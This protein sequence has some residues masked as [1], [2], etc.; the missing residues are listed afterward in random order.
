MQISK[1]P[2]VTVIVPGF[3]HELYVK[4]TITSIVNQ[5]YGFENIQL[6]TTNDASTDSTGLILEELSKK[7]NF[8][9][10]NN[11][12]NLGVVK[13]LNYML[14]NANGKYISI[15]A[16]DDYWDKDKLFKQVTLMESLDMEYAMCHT[17]APVIDENNNLIFYQDKGVEFQGNIFPKILVENS[18][19]AS[20]VIFRKSI[21]EEIGYFDEKIIFEDRDLWIRIGLKYKVAYINEPLVFRRQ[22]KCNQGRNMD[23]HYVVMLKLFEKYKIHFE[24]FNL[25]EKFHYDMFNSM[26]AYDFKKSIFH[27]RKTSAKLIFQSR[28][29]Y[30]LMKLLIPKV[31]FKNMK[32]RKLLNRW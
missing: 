23:L 27:F 9:H 7:Y 32:L 21:L 31:I 15:C 5:T 16:S 14:E 13:S 6:I 18:I 25:V 19:V 12:V 11:P 30:I 1:K 8:T 4:Q 10:V 28:T 26:S 20:S 3:N 24:M 22:H 29:L 17:V 2:L